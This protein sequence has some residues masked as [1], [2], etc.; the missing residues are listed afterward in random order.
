MSEENIALVTGGATGIGA[1]ICRH[2]LAAGYEVVVLDRG[3]PDWTDKRL[4][5]HEIDLLDA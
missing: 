5:V 3:R 4:H 1:E 2:M